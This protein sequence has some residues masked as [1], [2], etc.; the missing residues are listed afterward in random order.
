M[1]KMKRKI[2]KLFSMAYSFCYG[3]IIY[4]R[5]TFNVHHN[6]P[7]LWFPSPCIS[8]ISDMG[9]D[10]FYKIHFSCKVAVFKSQRTFYK[11]N[12]PN[13]FFIELD[14]SSQIIQHSLNNAHLGLIYFL[15]D[16]ALILWKYN[17]H[18]ALLSSLSFWGSIDSCF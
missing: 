17:Y 15:S 1:P 13:S 5:F 2:L 11:L 6:Y 4:W 10:Y 14:N 18:I 8:I 7:K 16:F 12:H 9:I 3:P